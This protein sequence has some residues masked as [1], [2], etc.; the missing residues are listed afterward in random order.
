LYPQASIQTTIS[1]FTFGIFTIGDPNQPHPTLLA[2]IISADP[3]STVLF[4]T[5]PPAAD[6]GPR[7]FCEMGS[8]LTLTQMGP[9]AMVDQFTLSDT[10]T[11]SESCAI[12][13]PAV[14][15]QSE[16]GPEAGSAA[17]LVTTTLQPSESAWIT[18]DVTAGAELLAQA[19]G[20]PNSTSTSTGKGGST[21]T[22]GGSP[23]S[24]GKTNG[25]ARSWVGATAVGI[26]AGA[27]GAMCALL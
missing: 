13:T 18:V 10:F 27:F 23:T 14:C 12:A 20:K 4:L 2:S 7:E 21:G 25:A 11:W 24:T 3:T 15:V 26:A 5:C 19:T 16:A 6:L 17:G 22:A 9:T 8:G 1:I